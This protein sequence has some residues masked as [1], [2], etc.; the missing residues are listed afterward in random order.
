[1]MKIVYL[2]LIALAAYSALFLI[3]DEVISPDDLIFE[4]FSSEL[5]R[6]GGRLGYLPPGDEIFG[7]KGFIPRYFVYGLEGRV[8]PRK[9]PGFILFW[10]GL[11]RILPAGTGRLINPLCA[12]LSILLLYLVGRELFP[13]ERTAFRAAVFLAVTPVFIRRA[14]VY[15]PTLFNLAVFLAALLF[16]LRSL[17]RGWWYDYLGFGIFSGVFLWIRPTNSIYLATFL[18]FFLIERRR[19]VGRYLVAA[20][21]LVLLGGA[22]LLF[23]NRT[24]YGG[25]FTLGYTAT[26]LQEAA[27]LGDT[28]PAGI[29][30]ILDYL[31][32]YPQ[33]WFPHIKNT[34]AAL[35]LG[36]P[37]LILALLG[38]ALPRPRPEL[39]AGEDES[40][41]PGE[42]GYR[43]ERPLRFKLYYLSLFVIAVGFFS[44]F[45]T[46]GH[47]KHEFTLHSSFLRYLMP[48]ICLLPLFAA[49]FLERVRLSAGR[50]I[51]PLAGFSLLIAL[52]APA[53]MIETTLQSRYNREV[54]DFL[55][56][57]SDERTVFFSHYW[58]KVLYPERIVY[59]LGT[60]FPTEM[61][62]EM[63]RKV[64][65]AGYRVAYPAHPADGMI[66]DFILQHYIVEEIEGPDRLSFL[67]RL[68]APF[69]PSRLYPVRLYLVREEKIPP[70]PAPA[71]SP[72]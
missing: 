25:Y 22:G 53:G 17:R 71:G 64:H 33:F 62:E 18:I 13:G 72:R 24:V 30:G 32:F 4:F 27:A 1:M 36:F 52:F 42:D 8:Y 7:E 43:P 14:F 23:F 35:A 38:F 41:L 39:S 51:T 59:T 12:A 67:S 65:R 37:L 56:F 69:I 45:G 47:E 68:A 19:V 16:L 58:D 20:L 9:F 61:A 48:M 50:M 34:P 60:H 28:A 29:R 31:R 5:G 21:A 63:I 66:G 44:N 55:R 6:P 54:G 2:L 26:H 10:G 11:R 70:E 46:F 15:N 3:S 40:G 49:R 57:H